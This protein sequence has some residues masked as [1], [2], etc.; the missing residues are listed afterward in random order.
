MFAHAHH[1]SDVYEQ[2]PQAAASRDGTQVGFASE[3][4]GTSYAFY[5]ARP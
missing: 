3:W 5:V 2:M 1:A 4:S